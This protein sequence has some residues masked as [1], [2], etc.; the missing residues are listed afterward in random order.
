ME[1]AN[2]LRMLAGRFTTAVQLITW[3]C[4]LQGRYII[5]GSVPGTCYDH[6]ARRSH[7]YA[8]EDE[9]L[10]AI[11]ADPWIQANPDQKIQRAD[12]SFVGR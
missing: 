7:D 2:A 5:V 3:P 6:E 11:L 9:A 10:A 12:Y 8:T 1:T 4:K